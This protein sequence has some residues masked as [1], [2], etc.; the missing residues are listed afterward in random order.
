MKSREYKADIAILGGGIA[1]LWLLNLLCDRGY[2]AVLIEKNTIGGHQTLASQGMI[3]GGIKY[4][5]GGL[6]SDASE[7]IAAMPGRWQSCLDGNGTID[8]RG[9]R[10]LSR[11]YFLFSDNRLSSRVTAFF[12]SKA[13]EGRVEPVDRE[14][15]PAVLRDHAFKGIVYRLQDVVLDTG[16]LIDQLANRYSDRICIGKASLLSEDSLVTGL[17]TEA[18]EKIS[19]SLY[20]LASGSGNGPMI[21]QLGLPVSQQ[22]RP[23]NQVVVHG[24]LP[25]LYAHAVSLRNGDKPRLTITSHK[26]SDSGLAW[27]LGGQL[28]ETGVERSDE[29]Q[30]AKAKKELCDIFPWLDFSNCTFTTF[31]VDRAEPAQE[32]QQRPDAPYARRFSNTLVCWP[33]KLTLAPMLGDMV[34]QEI[35]FKGAANSKVAWQEPLHFGTPPWD[36]PHEA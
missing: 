14:D 28:A 3:H 5:L 19:A 6:L 2:N 30:I 25:E 10:T 13:V 20:I 24:D 17:V 33:T 9:V 16:A 21:D 22:L 29:T 15:R 4:A 11:D 34:L 31:R 23:L 26:T 8:L 7:T 18:G 32:D 27:Y 1:G 36:L 35:D 12:G